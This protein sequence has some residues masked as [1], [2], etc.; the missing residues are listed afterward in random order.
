[1][2]FGGVWNSNVAKYKYIIIFVFLIWTG[3][4]SY[5]ASQ[6]GPLTEEEEFLPADHPISQN[7]KILTE[8]F[9]GNTDYSELKIV[10]H[11]G[12]KELDK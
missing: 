12:V 9:G 7:T 3:V 11:F 8:R 2:F 10:I 4:A 5:L 1:M 6:M